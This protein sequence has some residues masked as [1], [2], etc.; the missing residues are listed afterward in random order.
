MKYDWDSTVVQIDQDE[1]ILRVL[2]WPRFFCEH[3]HLGITCF[4]QEKINMKRKIKELSVPKQWL[5]IFEWKYPGT[6]KENITYS[7]GKIRESD[8]FKNEE[9]TKSPKNIIAMS[10]TANKVSRKSMESTDFQQDANSRKHMYLRWYTNNRHLK[11]RT[12]GKIKP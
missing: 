2:F 1:G 4:K 11:N 9:K 5:Q 8:V 3:E 10:E 12:W 7:T 6:W